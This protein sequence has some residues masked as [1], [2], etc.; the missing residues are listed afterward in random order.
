MRTNELQARLPSVERDAPTSDIPYNTMGLDLS[1]SLTMPRSSG[2]YARRIYACEGG[3]TTCKP[4]VLASVLAT[5]VH[6]HHFQ[7]NGES[8]W[9]GYSSQPLAYQPRQ[10]MCGNAL[11]VHLRSLEA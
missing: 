2:A 5:I 3:H 6:I 1:R 10:C 11:H 9:H 4:L 7:S 8:W